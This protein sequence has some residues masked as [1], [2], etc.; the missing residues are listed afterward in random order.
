MKNC[1]KF[2]KN[3]CLV[4]EVFSKFIIIIGKIKTKPLF[5][6]FIKLLQNSKVEILNCYRVYYY[7]LININEFIIFLDYY[8]FF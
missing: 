2:Y 4:L 5:L 6:K 3:P 8:F 1:I 7:R